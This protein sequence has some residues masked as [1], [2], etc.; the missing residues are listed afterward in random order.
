MGRAKVTIRKGELSGLYLGRGLSTRKIA[1]IY[2]CSWSTVMN[3]ITEL[4]I[5][6]KSQAA[7]RM[8]YQKFDF[9]GTEL[10]RAYM[11]GFRVGDLNVYRVSDNSETLVVRCHTT[12]QEQVDIMESLFKKFGHVRVSVNKHGH[13]HVNCFLNNSFLFLFPKDARVWLEM[14]EAST[15]LAFIAGYTDAEGNFILN[16][17]RARFKID[18]YDYNVLQSSARWLAQSGVASKLRLIQHR[19]NLQRIRGKLGMYHGDLWRLNINEAK[20][21]AKFI[22]LIRPFL[23]HR[24]RLRDLDASYRNIAE[25]IK[26]GTIK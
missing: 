4:G 13:Y 12:Q 20:S 21:L 10:E 6:K 7:A 25:R 1:E 16:Q 9:N 2:G 18:S 3:R 5:P 19:G 24:Q 14:K 23:R 26:N 8:R 11:I 17:G 15:R 22:V